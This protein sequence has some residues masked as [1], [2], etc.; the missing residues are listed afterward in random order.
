MS[1]SQT[2]PTRENSINYLPAVLKEN[3]T[4][5]LIEYYA[6]NPQTNKLKRKQIRLERLVRRYSGKR[7]ARSH[8]LQIT[9]SINAKLAG[10]WSPFFNTED[11]RLY[12]K[13]STVAKI[14]LSEKKKELRENTLR[15]YSSF[16]KML[17]EWSQKT[18]PDLY[19]SMFTKIWAV[20]YM[21][22]IYN[23]RNCNIT[24]YNNQIKMGRALFNWAKE[25]C[26][27]R[28][29]PFELIK[30]KPKQKKQ[31]TIIPPEIREKIKQYLLKNDPNFLPVCELVFFSLIRPNE[32]KNL[33]VGDID[34]SGK[35]IRVSGEIAKNH[36]TRHSALNEDLI[37]RLSTMVRGT[38]KDWFVFGSDLRPAKSRIGNGRFGYHWRKM[39]D[40]L[41]LPSTMQLYS[42]RDTGIFEMLK[43]GID[44]L[45]VMQHADH[46]SLN[47]TTIYANHADPNLTNLIY[48]K[49]PK[50]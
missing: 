47:I 8:C 28:E 40:T 9:N 20:R 15:S 48:T 5:W 32:I 30:L 13:L 42:L 4:G 43:S 39:R 44:D 29:N 16:C 26:Y 41:K 1:L 24:T 21:D 7:E 14:F 35:A 46:S 33:R 36:N 18:A 17:L 10:G 23:E 37:E 27:S 12:E 19:C 11:S 25:R 2:P 3:K 50:F 45:S 31:R 38:P 22:Y 6:Q 49:G 34:F